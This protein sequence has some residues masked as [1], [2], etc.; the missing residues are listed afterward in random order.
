MLSRS[1]R[2]QLPQPPAN[3]R[4]AAYSWARAAR[5]QPR[6]GRGAGE[7]R[8]GWSGWQSRHRSRSL[9][10]LVA[11]S[12][13]PGLGRCASEGV[14]RSWQ[15]GA[16]RGGGCSGIAV[17]VTARGCRCGR[18]R[19]L[20]CR[21]PL[22]PKLKQQRHRWRVVGRQRQGC[23]CGRGSVQ[24]YS[25]QQLQIQAPLRVAWQRQ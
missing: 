13:L 3:Q 17:A 4:T 8:S 12:Q 1:R 22:M 19:A 21:C 5:A 20:E 14:G 23:S 9:H 16:P 15:I 11:Q 2:L 10:A 24:G 18:G 25:H 6:R 7:G